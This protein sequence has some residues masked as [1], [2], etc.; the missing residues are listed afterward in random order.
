MTI[1]QDAPHE[2]LEFVSHSD[3]GG[4]GDGVRVAVFLRGGRVFLP[5]SLS[6]W[7]LLYA[8]SQHAC[9]ASR[10]GISFARM[11]PAV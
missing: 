11:P 9:A 7:I 2:N 10:P 3:R 6:S 8:D 4:R 5:Q 1:P